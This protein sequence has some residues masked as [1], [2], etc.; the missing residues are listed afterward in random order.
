MG[1]LLDNRRKTT[2]ALLN[3]L[4]Q[5]LVKAKL[6]LA[7]K[8][9]IYATGSVARGEASKHSDLDLFIVGLPK[10]N[11]DKK[12]RLLTRLDE[13]I[14]KADLIEACRKR[15]IPDFSGDGEYL[16]HY[17]IGNLCNKLGTPHD[18]AH[19]TFTA[20]LLLLL[21]SRCLAE[22]DVYSDALDEVIAA[23]W[24]DYQEYSDT[25]MPA[26]LANDILRLWKTFCVNYEARTDTETPRQRAKRRLTNHKLKHSRMLTCYS[27]LAYLALIFGQKS[28]VRPEDARSMTLLSPTQRLEHIQIERFDCKNTIDR[29]I[30]AYE[31]FLTDTDFPKDELVERFSDKDKTRTYSQ[32][33]HD[34]GDLV[35][36]LL[37]NVATPRF[38]RY[39]VV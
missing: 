11:D 7:G 36:E 9:C 5:S 20:R 23:Y 34:F 21:E 8:A 2:H 32:Q 14:V 18:D 29:I 15:E 13:I 28:T 24:R 38:Y 1:A 31:R 25:F 12:Q 3:D 39:L 6:A 37:K 17:T 4:G 35:F 30:E 26:F 33:A 16:V 19:N 10:T 27:A 22:N